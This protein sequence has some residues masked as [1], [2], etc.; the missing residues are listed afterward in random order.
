LRLGGVGGCARIRCRLCGSAVGL[1]C[2]ARATNPYE[3]VMASGEPVGSG[4]AARR[5]PTIAARTAAVI[6]AHVLLVTGS[7]LALGGGRR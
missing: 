7:G 4:V 5:A 6:T 3:S 2:G 1:E